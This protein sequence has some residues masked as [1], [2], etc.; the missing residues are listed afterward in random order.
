MSGKRC[1][2]SGDVEMGIG[3]QIG[4]GIGDIEAMLK[5]AKFELV[6]ELKFPFETWVCG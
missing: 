2:A 3:G 4:V 1:A 5:P 6:L